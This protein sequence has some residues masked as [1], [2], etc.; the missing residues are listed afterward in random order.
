[1]VR[2]SGDL[3]VERGHSEAGGI[4]H[5]LNVTGLPVCALQV[6]MVLPVDRGEGANVHPDWLMHSCFSLY[7]NHLEVPP[8][9]SSQSQC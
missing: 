8:A 5:D 7:C 9:L 1:M 3:W 2:S 6:V 4:G